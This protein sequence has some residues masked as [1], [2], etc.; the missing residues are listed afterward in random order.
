MRL[1]HTADFPEGVTLA[2]DL[3]ARP[4]HEHLPRAG[5]LL[6]EDERA[7]LLEAG[8]ARVYVEDELS[9]DIEVP[10]ALSDTTREAARAAVGRAFTDARRMPG[11]LLARER[12][13][14]L[15][16]A[17]RAIVAE[18][19]RLPDAPFAFAD[20]AGADAY[21]VEH[22]LDATVVGL[23]VGRRLGLESDML[24]QLGQGLFLQDIGM[25]ALPPSILHK[26]G[27]LAADELQL[28]TRHPVRGLDFLRGADLGELA[29]SVV[30]SHHERWDGGGYPGGLAGE[31]ISRFARIAA[32]ADVF[33]AVT[34]ERHHAP[35]ASQRAGV[36]A[37]RAAAG[38]ALDPELVEVFCDLV[39]AHPPGSELE[40][41]D[42]CRGV[43]ASVTDEGPVVRVPG[44]EIA[45]A[46]AA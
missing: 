26:P 28:M 19:E 14:E 23:L 40:L 1:V 7:A 11:D 3:P 46:V 22:S 6:G 38:G 15:T 29:E 34:S 31:E 35:A 12:L 27:P 4:G 10:L 44:A 17:A 36:A 25:L 39:V 20:L 45:I 9:E 18:V 32:V 30:R 5:A 24:L 8:I 42:G 2:M 41:P 13:E 21:R 33:D 37:V 43:V 16:A